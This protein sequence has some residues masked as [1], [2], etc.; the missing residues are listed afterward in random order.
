MTSG[1]QGTTDGGI[2]GH[3]VHDHTKNPGI[4]G[5]HTN[6]TNAVLDNVGSDSRGTVGRNT[7]TTRTHLKNIDTNTDPTRVLDSGNGTSV[8]EPTT[9]TRGGRFHQPS[10]SLERRPVG[11][12]QGVQRVDHI[13]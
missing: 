9:P 5:R 1:A 8:L 13:V 6:A 3:G 7:N 2:T 11:G 4:L 10:K 12:G